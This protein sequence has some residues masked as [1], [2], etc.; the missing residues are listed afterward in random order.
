MLLTVDTRSTHA[1]ALEHNHVH[2]ATVHKE[3]PQRVHRTHASSDGSATWGLWRTSDH[4]GVL[5]SVGDDRTA[6]VEVGD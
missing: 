5:G 3:S 1:L 4:N 2:R 6:V